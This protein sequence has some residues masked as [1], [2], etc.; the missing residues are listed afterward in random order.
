MDSNQDEVAEPISEDGDEG[1]PGEDEE[2]L[3]PEEEARE[4]EAVSEQISQRRRR[5]MFIAI[6]LILAVTWLL[7]QLGDPLVPPNP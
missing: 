7:G 4:M 5:R 2:P 1:F 6:F 3:S